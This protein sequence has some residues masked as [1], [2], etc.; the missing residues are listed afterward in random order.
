MSDKNIKKS[1]GI[2]II[3]TGNAKTIE[4]TLVV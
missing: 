4:I 1:D 2:P 3:N